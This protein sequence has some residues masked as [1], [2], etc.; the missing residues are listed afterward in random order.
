VGAQVLGGGKLF[1]GRGVQV[2]GYKGQGA[3]LG[4]LVGY[5]F[6]IFIKIF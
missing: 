3:G 6:E 5:I 1:G 4:F 2:I